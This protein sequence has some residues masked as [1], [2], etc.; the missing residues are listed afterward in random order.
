[1]SDTGDAGGSAD[2]ADG[3]PVGGLLSDTYVAALQHD[4]VELPPE[5]TRIGV[6]RDPTPWFHGSVDE[7]LQPLGPPRDLLDETKQ[8][9][10][11]LKRRG[12]CDE[13]AHNAAWEETDFASRYRAH[14]QSS[15]AAGDAVDD[16]LARLDSGESIA[17]V[18]F[19]NTSNKRCHR[20]ILHDHLEAERRQDG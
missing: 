11:D 17:L 13:E 6:V 20:T 2:A 3:A 10:T 5:T 8:A 9:E 14:L 4:L 7:N 16:L 19:E 18:C 12:I 15:D 1:M